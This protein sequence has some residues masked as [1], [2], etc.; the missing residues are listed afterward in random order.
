MGDRKGAPRP[1]PQDGEHDRGRG[2]HGGQRSAPM[3]PA[4]LRLGRKWQGNDFLPGEQ[5]LLQMAG[6]GAERSRDR[7]V[8]WKAQCSSNH[9]CTSGS[10]WQRQGL[11]HLRVAMVDPDRPAGQQNALGVLGG[12]VRSPFSRLATKPFNWPTPRAMRD[13]TVPRGTPKI[14]AI[15]S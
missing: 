4:R 9:R 14:C 11:R 10:A 1:Q 15:S 2:G 13:F 8:A 3:P 5:R 6:T 7:T 12:H